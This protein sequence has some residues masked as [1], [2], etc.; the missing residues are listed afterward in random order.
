[1]PPRSD[2]TGYSQSGMLAYVMAIVHYVLNED[3][4]RSTPSREYFCMYWISD[5]MNLSRFGTVDAMSEKRV[6]VGG[7]LNVHPP[8]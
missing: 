1:M 2:V 7:S 6:S 5:L 4:P 3:S 8:Y